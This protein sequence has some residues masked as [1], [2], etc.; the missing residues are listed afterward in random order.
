MCSAFQILLKHEDSVVQIA[1]RRMGELDQKPWIELCKNR[2]KN[3]DW[4]TR[5]GEIY[6]SWQEYLKDP[7]WYPFKVITSGDKAQVTL[8]VFFVSF[9]TLLFK[10]SRCE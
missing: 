6:S 1:M 2:Y 9:Y 3:G 5:C 4:Q 7:S 8:A 10:V